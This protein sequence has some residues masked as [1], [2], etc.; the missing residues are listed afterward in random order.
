MCYFGGAQE[1]LTLG[2][3]SSIYFVG[4][5]N[6]NSESSS[7]PFFHVYTK[8]TGVGDQQPWYHSKIDYLYNTV[9]N[10]IGIGE[11]CIFYSIGDPSSL[12]SERKIQFNNI[13]VNGDGL[14]A[15]EILYIVLATNSSATAGAVNITANTLGFDTN[16]GITRNLKLEN[17]SGL[18]T[19]DNQILQL[20]QET[21]TALNTTAIVGL[22]TDIKTV[23]GSIAGDTN[24]IN[25]K[26][27]SGADTTLA[28][29]QQVLSYGQDNYRF[30]KRQFL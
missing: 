7:I 17:D 24:S 2:E 8:P 30:G 11:D 5:I 13:V 9:D 28:S 18:S 23:L 1:T 15:E 25:T 16:T 4:S 19:S 3:L 12:F 20:T 22:Q 6:F 10:T 21:T 14:P 27:T 26:M 29:A